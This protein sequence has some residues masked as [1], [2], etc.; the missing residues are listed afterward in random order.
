MQLEEAYTVVIT[1]LVV[2]VEC[3]EDSLMQ[4]GGTHQHNINAGVLDS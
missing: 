4:I 2:F 3:K 1:K